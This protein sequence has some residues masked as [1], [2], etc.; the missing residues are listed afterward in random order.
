ML[1]RRIELLNV[2]LFTEHK[3]I[4]HQKLKSQFKIGVHTLKIMF[5]STESKRTVF[6]FC[7][8]LEYLLGF[9][10]NVSTHCIWKLLNITLVMQIKSS[11][12]SFIFFLKK[13]NG[14]YHTTSEVGLLLNF[15]CVLCDSLV[16]M[17]T[18]L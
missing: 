13:W 5:P 6:V 14:L 7:S 16:S 4:K 2:H 10:E 17:T 18:C 11:C 3:I 1:I 9:C 12:T 8:Q 15:V